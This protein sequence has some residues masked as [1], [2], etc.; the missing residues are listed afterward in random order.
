MVPKLAAVFSMNEIYPAAL[1]KLDGL[2]SDTSD[3]E[4]TLGPS[5]S[6]APGTAGTAT[7][8]GGKQTGDDAE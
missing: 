3:T 5:V 7:E 4:V 8:K 2:L 6:G 1:S